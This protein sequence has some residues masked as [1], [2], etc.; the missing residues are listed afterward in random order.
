MT[1]G[2]LRVDDLLEGRLGWQIE[3]LL[4]AGEE[5]V[6]Q[7]RLRQRHLVD[8]VILHWPAESHRNGQPPRLGN[9][10]LS[11]PTRGESGGLVGVGTGS[12]R[13]SKAPSYINPAERQLR[14]LPLVPRG[15]RVD[16]RWRESRESTGQTGFRGSRWPRPYRRTLNTRPGA[17]T[18]GRAKS[19]DVLKHLLKRMLQ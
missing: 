16:G 9:E 19:C 7:Q 1:L 15:R 12:V 6:V 8:R 11:A 18:D 4:D 13:G 3:Q 5:F 17:N 14:R 10:P 2:L